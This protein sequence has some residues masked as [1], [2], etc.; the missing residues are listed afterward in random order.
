MGLS[1]ESVISLAERG[2]VPDFMV[3]RGIRGLIGIRARQLAGTPFHRRQQVEDFL[4]RNGEHPIALHTEDANRQHYEV[5]AAFFQQVLGRRLKYSCCYW[6]EGVAALDEA[7]EAMLELTA[8]RARVADGQRILELGCGWGSLTLWMA[9]RFPASSITAVS[10]SAGQRSFIE[11]A[12][13]REKL[14]NVRVVT[15]DVNRYE[16]GGTFDRVVSV[17]MFEHVRNH[18]QLM[19]R[20]AGWLE[21]SGLLFVHI[22]CHRHTPYEYQT[23]GAGNWMGRHFFTGGVMPSDDLLLYL[24]RDL[25]LV[26]HW[27]LDGRHYAR[28]AGSWLRRMDARRPEILPVLGSVYGE[29]GRIR[30]FHR[31]RMFFMACQEL[32]AWRG[33]REWWVSHYLFEKRK[34]PGNGVR[35]V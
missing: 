4:R 2:L 23:D 10:N 15:A 29:Q 12:C 30:W 34:D 6:P 27:R 28:T 16:P 5:P 35:A 20:I 13:R 25:A 31:W 3:R 7:E 11:E 22:F 18:R 19:G 9:R 14:D 32:F 17:E 33:G 24:Q 26:R 21:P 1:G 8:R